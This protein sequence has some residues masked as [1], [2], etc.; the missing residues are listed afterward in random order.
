MKAIVD[1]KTLDMVHVYEGDVKFGGPWADVKLFAHIEIPEDVRHDHLKFKKQGLDIVCEINDEAISLH[2]QSIVDKQWEDL[3]AE[4]NR[5]LAESDWTQ[6]AD[7][8]LDTM[9]KLQYLNYRQ[10]LRDLPENT[11][12]PTNPVWPVKP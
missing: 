10:A 9:E 12:D 6:L 11:E 1:K 3:R 8:P 5:R 2:N 4:R 7:C